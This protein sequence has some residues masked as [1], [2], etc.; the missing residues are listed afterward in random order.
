MIASPSRRAS[1]APYRRGS[2]G[3]P[4]IG[5]SSA[6]RAERLAPTV[7]RRTQVA[8]AL[9]DQID[10]E[11][12]ADKGRNPLMEQV[13]KIGDSEALGARADVIGR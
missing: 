13:A 3:S 8:R 4:P 11:F 7:E 5:Q 10:A 9:I 1:S 12:A 2:A 6:A